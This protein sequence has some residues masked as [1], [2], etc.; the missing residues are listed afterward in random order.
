MRL[1]FSEIY[2]K[3]VE[4]IVVWS[5]VVTD[6]DV[7]A[8]FTSDINMY[9]QE[10][11]LCMS[12]LVFVLYFN[13]SIV[14]IHVFIISGFNFGSGENYTN[15]LRIFITSSSL[16]DILQHDLYIDGEICYCI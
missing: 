6:I 8:T 12:L 16:S 9:W 4:S 15:I 10:V 13:F 5:A 14:Y 1:F 2:K 3:R 11:I 7:V